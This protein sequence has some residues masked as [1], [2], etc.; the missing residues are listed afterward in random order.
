MMSSMHFPEAFLWQ[1]FYYLV[2]G[3]VKFETGPFK[4][5]AASRFG[6]DFPEAYLLHNDIK[7]DNSES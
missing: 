6:Q 5:L 1:V 7:P 2:E 4:N 3:C